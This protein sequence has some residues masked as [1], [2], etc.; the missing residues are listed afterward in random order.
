[1]SIQV[2]IFRVFFL[3][4][5]LEHWNTTLYLIHIYQNILFSLNLEHGID[6][7]STYLPF[8]ENRFLPKNGSNFSS[9]N[10]R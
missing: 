7:R 9:T 2:K 8:R 10:E 4:I 1:M 6:R 5:E 3:L